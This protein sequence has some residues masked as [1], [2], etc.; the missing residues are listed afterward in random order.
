MT[1]NRSINYIVKCE[2]WT[3]EFHIEILKRNLFPTADSYTAINMNTP[4]S[5]NDAEHADC[6]VYND[7]I[8]IYRINAAYRSAD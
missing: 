1:A 7:N 5:I 4:S 8:V 2:T 3:T 6:R